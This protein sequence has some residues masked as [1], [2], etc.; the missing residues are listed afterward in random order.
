[1]A[2]SRT[3][4]CTLHGGGVAATSNYPYIWVG[5]DIFFERDTTDKTK[6][7]WYTDGIPDN[8]SLPSSGK[9][10][11]KFFAYIAVNPADPYNPTW[12]E[13]WT[14]IEKD[15]TTAEYWWSTSVTWRADR[16]ASFTC[17]DNKATVYLYVKERDSCQNSGVYCYNDG[18]SYYMIDYFTVDLPEYETFYTVSYNANGG[19]G[20]PDSQTKSSLSDLTLS[21][22]IPT[23]PLSLKYYNNADGSLSNS[24]TIYRQFLGW[25]TQPDGHGTD[26]AAGGTYSPNASCTLYAKW[27]S[28]AFT[29][30]TIPDVY[31]TVTYNY[32]GGTGSPASTTVR[33]S[34]DGYAKTPN[35]AQAFVENHYYNTDITTDLNLYP[36]RG[37]GTLTS[38]PTPTKTGAQFLG[39]YTN[40]S[41]TGNKVTVPYTITGNITLYAKW[42]SLPIHQ[43]QTNGKWD[44]S[45]PYVWR[46]NGT[47]WERV[48]HVY[49]FDET[50]QTWKD[51]SV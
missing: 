5:F 9:F 14:I 46:F 44:S 41:Y 51:L 31:Y 7:N 43:F 25:N 4:N 12:D 16:S 27:G 32:M 29:T 38:I 40:S 33:R 28:A 8:I 34:E 17:T 2:T 49:K 11:Y 19:S 48:A 13:L 23:Y 36:R 15:N 35:G 10:G 50:S 24:Y 47:S 3:I 1:M 26:Y 45:G 37:N 42:L 6:V 30:L 18:H 22:V 21:N 39:W 20:A